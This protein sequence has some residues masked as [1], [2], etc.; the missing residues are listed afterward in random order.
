MKEIRLANLSAQ[1]KGE[2]RNTDMVD[3][4]A[5]GGKTILDGLRVNISPEGTT[6]DIAQFLFRVNTNMVQ[7]TTEI[8]DEPSFNRG[9]STSVVSSTTNRNREL[10]LLRECD[11]MHDILGVLD[12]NYN[13]GFTLSV[14][15]PSCNC[16]VI[17]WV[18]GSHKFPF[19]GAS[20]R[21]KIC[22]VDEE[23]E[24]LLV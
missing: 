18:F 7:M 15:S 4:S 10:I 19:D 2:R 11:G 20:E 14:L 17:A 21:G 12:K 13:T 8:N 3:C 5:N 23:L 1:S 6:P 16:S 9:G 22:H 24:R